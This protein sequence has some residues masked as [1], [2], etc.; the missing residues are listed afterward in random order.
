MTKTICHMSTQ[1]SSVSWLYL[2]AERPWWA[3]TPGTPQLTAKSPAK[4]REAGW[5]EG[6][7]GS[8]G[9]SGFWVLGASLPGPGALVSPYLAPGR[10]HRTADLRQ[11]LVI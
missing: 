1:D 11:L 7:E 9:S 10:G 8:C 2:S 3:L 4:E 6:R 5:L